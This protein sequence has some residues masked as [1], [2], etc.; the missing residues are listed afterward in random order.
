MQ[1][2]AVVALCL[3]LAA[4][5]PRGPDV[6]AGL[7]S[8]SP[9]A[10]AQGAGVRFEADAVRVYYGRSDR[11]LLV[12]PAY[13]IERRKEGVRIR[14]AHGEAMDRRTLVLERRPDD[15]LR[16]V[17]HAFADK[18]TGAVSLRLDGA[19][20]GRYFDLQL[21][22]EAPPAKKRGRETEGLAP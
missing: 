1:R 20:S 15:T 11:A 14:I 17:T 5:A 18:G 12:A 13:E 3:A 6:L 10:C 7:W 21:C 9:E 22:P 4:C 16:A 8:R 2:P 19:G